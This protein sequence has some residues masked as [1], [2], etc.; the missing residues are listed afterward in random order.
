MRTATNDVQ[1]TV[2]VDKAVK[3]STEIL[4]SKL[5]LNMTTA[6]NIF[7]R[8]AIRENGIPFPVSAKTPS[9]V[10]GYTEDDITNTFRA[11]ILNE[12]ASKKLTNKPVEKYDIESNRAY[13]D[14][15]MVCG[16]TLEN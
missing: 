1:V 13:L 6:F 11:A 9:F 2:R 12:I 7:L 5:G 4:F 14:I 15:L 16:N 10:S 8:T 3:E